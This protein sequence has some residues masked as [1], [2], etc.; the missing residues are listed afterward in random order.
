MFL[1]IIQFWLDCLPPV[2]LAAKWLLFPHLLHCWPY[3][4]H[5]DLSGT[6]F[7]PQTL[8]S[9]CWVLPFADFFFSSCFFRKNFRFFFPTALTSCKFCICFN[10]L[11]VASAACAISRALFSVKSGTRSKCSLTLLSAIPNTMCGHISMNLSNL[12]IHKSLPCFVELWH[13]WAPHFPVYAERID[14]FRKLYS[15]KAHNTAENALEL[16]PF[17]LCFCHCPMLMHC[18]HLALCRRSQWEKLL[19]EWGL[20]FWLFR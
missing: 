3:A 10:W 11:W 6:C 4:G 15:C 7:L 19:L 8:Q 18:K 1:H 5:F 9:I 16:Y 17:W 12:A 20:P 14:N 2:H 13:I